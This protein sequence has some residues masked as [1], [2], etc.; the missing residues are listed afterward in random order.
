MT[1]SP[2]IKES[3]LS[4]ETI[5]MISHQNQWN[6]FKQRFWQAEP[7]PHIC[8]DNFLREDL[9]QQVVNDFRSIDGSAIPTEV[10]SSEIELNKVC[11][12]S[13]SNFA[14]AQEV[15]DCLSRQTFIQLIESLLNT[16]NIIPLPK[17]RTENKSTR[18]YLHIMK[19]GGFLGSH[20]DQSHIDQ[21]H[22]HILSCIFYASENWTE[23]QGGH[24]TLFNKDGSQ[25]IAKIDYKPNRL[26]IF[27]HTSESFHG[28]SKLNTENNRYSIYM[29]Y[30]LPIQQLQTFKKAFAQL[31]QKSQPQYWQ[32]DVIFFSTSKKN[33]NYSRQYNQYIIDSH[34]RAMHFGAWQY[35]V[36]R[37]I[38]SIKS[39]LRQLKSKALKKIKNFTSK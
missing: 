4:N 18:K 12:E 25:A 24:T 33:N 13:S 2:A 3:A 11:F 17:F 9:F 1:T 28:V 37:L 16:N 6:E 23:E 31:S 21:T 20:V 30:Y 22:I 19:D 29:D 27:L 35:P 32:H 8:I 38:N 36:V 14:N 34:N 10:Y 26:A 15:V 5:D 7:Y 39:E